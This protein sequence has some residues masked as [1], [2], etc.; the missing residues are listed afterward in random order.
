MIG[1]YEVLDS[2]RTIEPITVR[3]PDGNKAV[4]SKVG[5]VRLGPRIIL[6][7]VLFVSKLKCKLISIR[8]LS[9]ESNCIVMFID[10]FCVIQDHISRSLI[11]VAR[12]KVR[13][14]L[15]KVVLDLKKQAYAV[16]VGDL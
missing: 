11:R 1:T 5:N 8:Q 6:K 15:S 2:I 10:S 16:R 12:V 3:L 13:F 14:F 9:K 7:D 4:A